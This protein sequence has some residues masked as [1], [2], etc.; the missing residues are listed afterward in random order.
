MLNLIWVRLSQI[1]SPKR[2]ISLQSNRT[3]AWHFDELDS[4][5]TVSEVI[6]PDRV[7]RIK[8][9]SSWW[10]AISHQRKS[11]LPGE[12]VRVIAQIN[13]TCVVEAAP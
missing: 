9:Q 3:S 6:H 5:A 4:L 11:L 7:G 2:T 1:F 10:P 8:Y 13:L 12:Q